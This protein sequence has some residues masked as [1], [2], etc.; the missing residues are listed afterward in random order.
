[1]PPRI[2]WDR[3]SACRLVYL[4][5]WAVC[6]RSQPPPSRQNAKIETCC[7]RRK[8]KKGKKSHE[9]LSVLNQVELEA[10][11]F[12]ST[13]RIAK[14]TN[15]VSRSNTHS[16]RS[17]GAIIARYSDANTKELREKGGNCCNR[18][19]VAEFDPTNKFITKRSASVGGVGNDVTHTQKLIYKL[20]NN[21]NN[22]KCEREEKG[23]ERE[24]ERDLK[25][26]Q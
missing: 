20:N 8:R 12:L 15:I 2:R 24:R 3:T 22:K 9:K 14:R 4:E 10:F 26:P 16:R 19:H 21:N 1:M 5:R 13:S 17:G 25:I 23:G 7:E 11:Y 18:S 6:H